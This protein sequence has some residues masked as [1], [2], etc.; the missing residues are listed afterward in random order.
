MSE[1]LKYYK[2]VLLVIESLPKSQSSMIPKEIIDNIRENAEKYKQKM[3]LKY[4][5]TGQVILS[6]EAKALITMLYQKYFLPEQERNIFLKKL[7]END[8]K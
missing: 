5:I 2:E 7:K 4:D 8:K 6:Y 3:E 1:A